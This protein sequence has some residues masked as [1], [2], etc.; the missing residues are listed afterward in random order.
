MIRSFVRIG[1]MGAET[2]TGLKL[3]GRRLAEAGWAGE[4]VV[5]VG[6]HGRALCR[7]CRM[8]ILAKRRRTWEAIYEI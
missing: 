8:E 2:R 6:A 5:E 7:W 1:G 4:E 3:P